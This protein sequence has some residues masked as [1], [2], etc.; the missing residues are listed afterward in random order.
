MHVLC[1][2]WISLEMCVGRRVCTRLWCV[3]VVRRRSWHL[4]APV[5]VFPGINLYPGLLG[6]CMIQIDFFALALFYTD[7][8]LEIPT[9]SFGNSRNVE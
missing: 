3:F 8:L 6:P 5:L 7:S 2:R 9:L 1:F 4:L